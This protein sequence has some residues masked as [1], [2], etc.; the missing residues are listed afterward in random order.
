MNVLLLALLLIPQVAPPKA[1]T[2]LATATAAEMAQY[3]AVLKTS[4][5]DITLEFLPDKAPET[6]R[7]FLELAAGGVYDGTLIFRVVPGFI[8]QTGAMAYRDVPLTMGQQRL[9]HN[10][11]AEFTDTP[12]VAGLVSMAHGDDPDSAQTSFFICTGDC[13]SLDGKFAVFARVTAGMD[14]VRAI[15]AVPV[16]GEKPQT[17]IGILKVTLQRKP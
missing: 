13:H 2:P 10:V 3:R 1:Q 8:L 16:D 14:V 5:G 12:N 6:V 17:S 9:V 4:L 11:P 15:G 7:N